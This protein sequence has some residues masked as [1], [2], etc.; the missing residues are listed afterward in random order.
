MQ[1]GVI[2]AGLCPP[3]VE[4]IAE[5]VG[6]EI[7]KSGAFLI[8]GGL[9]GVMEAAARGAKFE[10]GFTIGI[11]P[12]IDSYEANPYIDVSIVTDMGHARNV[13]LVRSSDALIAVEGGFGTLSE[14]AIAHFQCHR[15]LLVPIKYIRH[16]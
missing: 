3:S 7:A 8:C 15:V 11:L 12:G 9:G 16:Q 6:R 14:I 1:I 10:G 4:K 13:I 2:G 5:D